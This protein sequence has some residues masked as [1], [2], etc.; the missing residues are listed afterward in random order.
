MHIILSSYTLSFFF[1][2]SLL[3]LSFAS[4]TFPPAAEPE[5]EPNRY[6]EPLLACGDLSGMAPRTQGSDADDDVSPFD[7]NSWQAL[8]PPPLLSPPPP[9]AAAAATAAESPSVSTLPSSQPPPAAPA[10]AAPSV[11]SQ[12]EDSDLDAALARALSAFDADDNT[13]PETDN[14]ALAS[15]A[16]R[17]IGAAQLLGSTAAHATAPFIRR[18]EPEE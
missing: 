4:L 10:A 6:L 18:N 5:K 16:S 11:Q 7:L 2:P 1:P 8:A 12:T 15:A 13:A 14:T 17:V 3:L 9:A